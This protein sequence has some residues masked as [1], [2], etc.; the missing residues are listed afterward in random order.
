MTAAHNPP[1][2]NFKS[3]PLRWGRAIRCVCAGELRANECKALKSYKKMGI[4]FIALGQLGSLIGAVGSL[5]GRASLF[6]L[7]SILIYRKTPTPTSLG[8]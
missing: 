5:S 8:G 6:A 1:G 3:G 7:G 4:K 2:P